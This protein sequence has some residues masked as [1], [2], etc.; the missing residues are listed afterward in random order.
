MLLGDFSTGPDA[1]R[2][3]RLKKREA[4]KRRGSVG[5]M[6]EVEEKRYSA[7]CTTA[8][9]VHSLTSSLSLTSAL[10][11]SAVLA[12]RLP[13]TTHVFS[14]VLLAV[15]LFGGWPT[16][17]KNVRVSPDRVHHCSLPGVWKVIL[18]RPHVIHPGARHLPLPARASSKPHLPFLGGCHQLAW[19]VDVVVRLALEDQEGWRLGCCEGQDP[20]AAQ[21]REG[22]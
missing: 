17:A 19:P 6:Q 7:R 18:T 15:G 5:Q 13:S 9:D 1:R 21:V 14:L 11:A 2:L 16:L 4:W 20:P 8:A 10:S 12:S 3:H 22:G